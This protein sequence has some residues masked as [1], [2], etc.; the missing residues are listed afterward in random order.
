MVEQQSELIANNE[1][2]SAQ[3]E[4]LQNQFEIVVE[5]L[6]EIKKER[7]RKAALKKARAEKKGLPKRQSIT[8]DIYQL[9]IQSVE[10]QNYKSARLRI[11]FCFLA[12]TG[13]QVSELLL[14][15]IN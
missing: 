3:L 9:F 2:L 13:I 7:E 1:K 8:P 14:L 5:E 4:D 11:A 15:K 12:V 10:G 6:A